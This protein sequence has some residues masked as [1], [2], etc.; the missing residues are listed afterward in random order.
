MN[1]AEMVRDGL[2]QAFLITVPVVATV[3]A[4]AVIVGAVLGRLGIRDALAAT[5][6]RALAVVVAL[7][8]MGG[9]MARHVVT[10]GGGL[11]ADALKGSP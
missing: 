8:M 2:L 6:I 5:V 10:Y 4:S 9:T 7:W 1:Q 11:W 3:T